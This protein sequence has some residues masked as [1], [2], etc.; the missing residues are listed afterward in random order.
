MGFVAGSSLE[1]LVRK[2]KFYGHP[3]ATLLL[4]T[5]HAWRE[6]KHLRWSA[7]RDGHTA[8][9]L[10]GALNYQPSLRETLNAKTTE[11]F[12]AP[13]LE[14]KLANKQYCLEAAADAKFYYDYANNPET[15][16]RTIVGI[17][18]APDKQSEHK[19]YFDIVLLVPAD[20][21]DGRIYLELGTTFD[22]SLI[23]I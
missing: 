21:V 18:V 13:Q 11:V 6:Y 1:G 22:L 23:H 4:N 3:D 10:L 7:R 17:R 5:K 16:G 12:I 9:Y 8:H 2:D 15:P 20:T 14:E 19:V